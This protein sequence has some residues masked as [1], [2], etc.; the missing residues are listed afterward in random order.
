MKLIDN[1]FQNI[2]DKLAG[3]IQQLSAKRKLGEKDLVKLK[4][5][6]QVLILDSV[7][8]SVAR[9]NNIGLLFINLPTDI[10]VL[11]TIIHQSHTEFTL[12]V[13]MKECCS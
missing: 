10:Q 8:L 6:I 1:Y 4:T 11:D 13:H 2:V 7:N 5:S 3:E 12:S 9:E